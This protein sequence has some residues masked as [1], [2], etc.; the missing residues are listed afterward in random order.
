LDELDEIRKR[1]L[2]KMMREQSEP[3]AQ[4]P[5]KPVVLTDSTLDSAVSQYPLLIVDCWAEWCGP[6]RMIAPVIEE[7]ARELAGK[8]VFGKLNVDENMLTA[9]R[10]RVTAIPTLLVFKGGKLVDKLVGAY[11]K[12]ALA[13][14]IR[15]HL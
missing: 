13:G 4:H 6:C 2:E 11:P 8:A 3:K 14:K 12:A 1:K 7:L 5:E 10:Y 15:R 9:S